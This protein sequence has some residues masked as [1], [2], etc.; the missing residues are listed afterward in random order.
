MAGM[1]GL[2]RV[3]IE[4]DADPGDVPGLPWELLRDPGTDR[5]LVVA[6]GQFVRTHQQAAGTP[7]SRL[8]TGTACGCC[9]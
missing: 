4:I 9:W 5:P 2:D 6:A 3:R 1:S 7:A 8:R